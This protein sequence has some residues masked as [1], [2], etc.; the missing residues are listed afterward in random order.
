MNPFE[1]YGLQPALQIDE[2]ALRRQY[3]SVQREWHPD[4]FAG[5]PDKE[6]EAAEKTAL[7]NRCYQKLSSLPARIQ[8]L[9]E[10]HGLAG[11]AGNVLP[12]SFLMEMMELHDE[13][14]LLKHN[15]ANKFVV[16]SAI[17][18]RLAEVLAEAEKVD[19]Q[20]TDQLQLLQ[21]IYQKY[22]YLLRL[23]DNLQAI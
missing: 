17:G 1:F 8:T 15:A 19:V 18:K 4:Y 9:L 20:K 6:A 2:A 5:I 21:G 7:N 12:G 16:E 11:D 22:R 13:I 14:E 3:L 23:M 10:L